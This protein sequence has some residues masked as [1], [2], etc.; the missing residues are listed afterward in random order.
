MSHPCRST[1][2]LQ[3][4]PATSCVWSQTEQEAT[5]PGWGAEGVAGRTE[6]LTPAPALPAVA[7]DT[8]LC[9]EWKEVK[10]LSPLSA[11]RPL[12]RLVRQA[13]FDSQDFLQ[14]PPSPAVPGQGA[15]VPVPHGGAPGLAVAGGAWGSTA[16][17]A[18]PAR[19][20]LRG[21][22]DVSREPGCI[23]GEIS[24]RCLV[25]MAMQ[26]VAR[27]QILH[28]FPRG[29]GLGAW[30]GRDGQRGHAAGCSGTAGAARERAPGRPAMVALHAHACACVHK[31][32]GTLGGTRRAHEC[33]RACVEVHVCVQRVHM[34]VQY[35]HTWSEHTCAC[36]EFMCVH[37]EEGPICSEGMCVCAASARVCL[38]SVHVYECLCVCIHG[39]M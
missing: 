21:C 19:S 24:P 39:V 16:H 34:C 22:S 23:L 37:H 8:T 5:I 7:V 13:S 14:V 31:L 6:V 18:L 36:S 10:A 30:R 11:T 26:F 1:Q 35:M 38:C 33:V 27:L 9:V 12:P 3:S 28:R 4:S 15:R 32:G 17:P 2:L 29:H 20:R 25:A